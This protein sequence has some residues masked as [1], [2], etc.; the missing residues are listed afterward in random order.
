MEKAINYIQNE[1]LKIYNRKF[2]KKYIKENILP[3]INFINISGKNKFLIGGSQGIGK[4]SLIKI[5]S[6]TLNKIYKKK[7]LSLSL[8]DY[9]L[10]KKQRL[11]LSKNKNKLLITRG[12]PGTHDIKK[13]IEDIKKFDKSKFPINT[14]LFDKLIDD[15]LKEKKIVKSKAD[16]LILEGWCCGCNEINIEYLYK[17]INKLEKNYDYNYSW[18]KYYNCKLKNEYKELFNLF[19]LSIFMKAPSFRYVY[20]W[21]YKQEIKNYS[22]SKNFKKMSINEIKFFIQ[23]FEKITKWMIKDLNKKANLVININKDQK[24]FSLK[25]N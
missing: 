15:V 1:S 21:R 5:I 8:D 13:L 20:D 3:I 25:I 2:S 18:R 16:I 11:N 14:P 9:Y 7:V 22:K 12:V 6:N 10:T 17:N 19:D 4:S 24:I 23:H